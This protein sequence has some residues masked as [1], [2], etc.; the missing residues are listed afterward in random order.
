MVN[1]SQKHPRPPEVIQCPPW[2]F[3]GKR[4]I[5]EREKEKEGEREGE[6]DFSVNPKSLFLSLKTELIC[7][8][9]KSEWIPRLYPQWVATIWWTVLAVDFWVCNLAMVRDNGSTG[10]PPSAWGNK[11]YTCLQ[12]SS[13]LKPPPLSHALLCFQVGRVLFILSPCLLRHRLA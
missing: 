10:L 5:R 13:L 1:T 3:Q 8:C 7:V 2:I 9:Q 12:K 6:G 4:G 11:S